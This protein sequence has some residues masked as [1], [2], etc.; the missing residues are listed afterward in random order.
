MTAIRKSAED[1]SNMNSVYKPIAGYVS[2]VAKE[3]KQT[4]KAWS[5]ALDAGTKARDARG[6]AAKAAAKAA[7]TAASNKQ[8]AQ[9][10]QL[11]GAILKGKRYND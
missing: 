11:A 4:V 7:A 10:G 1:R 6:A 2:N 8:T 9:A 5:N 3:A